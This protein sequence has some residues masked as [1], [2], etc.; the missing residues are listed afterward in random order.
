MP[1]LLSFTALIQQ[2]MRKAHVLDLRTTIVF[3]LRA[4][5][6]VPARV[7]ENFTVAVFNQI[8]RNG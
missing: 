1:P 2:E 5:V 3:A 8:R 7:D 4:D 6:A